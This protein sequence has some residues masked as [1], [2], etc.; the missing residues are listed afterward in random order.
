MDIVE[1]FENKQQ[2]NVYSLLIKTYLYL[3]QKEILKKYV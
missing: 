2:L 3:E 1:I